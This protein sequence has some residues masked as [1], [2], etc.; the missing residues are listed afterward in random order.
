MN[1][2]QAAVPGGFEERSGSVL[3]FRHG[4]FEC[5]KYD[6]RVFFRLSG[7]G[8]ADIQRELLLRQRRVRA[9]SKESLDILAAA[10]GFEDGE[11][12]E[13]ALARNSVLEKTP[14]EVV[15]ELV[16]FGCSF[17]EVIT[18]VY[19]RFKKTLGREE[20]ATLYKQEYKRYNEK[21]YGNKDTQGEGEDREDIDES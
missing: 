14:R 16:N 7:E 4:A 17:D 5:L 9:S 20:L 3:L 21:R 18:G 2:D 10:S 1:Y 19:P 15:R 11:G 12:I 13:A 8:E 6:D